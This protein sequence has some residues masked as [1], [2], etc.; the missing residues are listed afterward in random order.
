MTKDGQPVKMAQ[1]IEIGHIFALGDKY[2]KDLGLTYLSKEQKNETPVMG[3]YGIGVSRL[4][5]AIIEQNHDEHGMILPKSVAPFDVHVIPL[6]YNKK[7][8]QK[9]F[10]DNL[11]KELEGNGLTVLVDDRDERPGSKF[12]DADLIG[13][14]WQ[15]VVGRAYTDGKVEVK[16]RKTGEKQELEVNKVLEF[17][18]E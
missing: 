15:V 16:N 6:D 12:N 14:P 18:K 4:I 10:T 17:I 5:S 7:E 11:V 3:S 1:G 9:E 2:A 13:M 8:D